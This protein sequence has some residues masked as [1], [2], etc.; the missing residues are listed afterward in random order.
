MMPQLKD[1]K[2][3]DFAE[4][5]V[6][7]S[8][9]LVSAF[10]QLTEDTNPIHMDDNYAAKSFFGRRVAHG[11]LPAAFIGTILGTM[12]PG[13]GT[14]YLYQGLE[15]KGPAFIGDTIVVRV[16]IIAIEQR[17]GRVTLRTTARKS[18]EILIDGQASILFRPVE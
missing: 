7:V 2:I 4:K 15:F 16:E 10:A 6:L 3:G 13:P 18:E 5:E 9:E 17:L 11:M 12:L 14:I 8:A 1:M